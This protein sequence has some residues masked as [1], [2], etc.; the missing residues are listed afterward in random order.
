MRIQIRRRQK[1]VAKDWLSIILWFFFLIFLKYWCKSG[2]KLF[3][4]YCLFRHFNTRNNIENQCNSFRTNQ[5]RR[6]KRR[7]Q[8]D[9]PN[10]LLYFYGTRCAKQ[11]KKIEPSF[12]ID[13]MCNLKSACNRVFSWTLCAYAKTIH[14][15]K[16][17]IN[18][19]SE[20]FQR[21]VVIVYVYLLP[22]CEL[23]SI[24]CDCN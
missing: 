6:W 18:F 3:W 4:W 11:N 24:W 13:S 15:L 9:K 20:L 23:S 8:I 2:T 5:N 7:K 14:T 16:K 1:T 17:K 10:K 12:R 21:F 22:V 19:P